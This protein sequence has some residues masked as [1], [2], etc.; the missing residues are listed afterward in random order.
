MRGKHY[1]GSHVTCNTSHVT[2]HTS[3]VTH[4]EH[5]LV[6][7]LGDG[8][9]VDGVQD[10]VVLLGLGGSDVDYFPLEVLGKILNTLECDL[11]L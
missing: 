10:L 5:E 11:K 1:G 3:H 8:A 4:L 2:R 9:D 7:P 6:P